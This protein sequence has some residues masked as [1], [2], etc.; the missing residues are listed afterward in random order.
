MLSALSALPDSLRT[1]RAVSVTLGETWRAPRRVAMRY[2]WLLAAPLLS[3]LRLSPASPRSAVLSMA[4]ST[5]PQFFGRDPRGSLLSEEKLAQLAEVCKPVTG[6]SA[7]ASDIA[8]SFTAAAPTCEKRE[9]REGEGQF[10]IEGRGVLCPARNFDREKCPR[11][12]R[13]NRRPENA[14]GGRQLRRVV[15]REDRARPARIG[16]ML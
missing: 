10:L 9:E 16:L 11:G 4:G 12:R 15:R 13:R 3:A 5:A 6:S 7:S 8:S 14:T 2:G 1:E